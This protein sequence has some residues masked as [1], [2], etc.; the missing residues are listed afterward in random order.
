[1]QLPDSD[2]DIKSVVED[3]LKIEDFGAK[4]AAKMDQDDFL[5]Y[6]RRECLRS[7]TID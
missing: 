6:V 2:F 1:M 4:R 5:A 7:R 3:V